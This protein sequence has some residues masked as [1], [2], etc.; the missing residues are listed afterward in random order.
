[1]PMRRAFPACRL[2]DR[3]QRLAAP[4]P[5]LAL[6]WLPAPSA[7]LPRLA[8]LALFALLAG[9]GVGGALSPLPALAQGTGPDTLKAEVTYRALMFV[10]WPAERETGR[11]LQLCTAADNA[12]ETAM[13][14]LAGRPIRHLAI[15]VRRVT[16]PE[17]LGGCH[18]LYLAEPRPAW[19]AAIEHAPL[20]VLSDAAGMLDQGAELNLQVEDGRIVFD[21]DLDAARRAG[22]TIS[23]KLLRLARFVR[24]PSTSP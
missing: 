8:R 11:A 7:L 18:V 1:M 2:R 22:L 10:T 21:V 15:E 9:L 17:Q 13:Q 19:R 4:R 14:S 23:A 24:H 6:A 20:L 5:A 3:F 12:L 16:R